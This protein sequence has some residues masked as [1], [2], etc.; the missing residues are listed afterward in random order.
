VEKD[1]LPEWRA[2]ADRL[3]AHGPLPGEM[4]RRVTAVVEY[5]RLRQEAWE[6]LVVA[7]RDGDEAKLARWRDKHQRAEEALKRLNAED[8]P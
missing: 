4:G 8:R 1:V 5:M 7:L 3:A 2:A 6:L